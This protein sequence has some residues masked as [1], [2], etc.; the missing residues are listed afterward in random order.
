MAGERTPEGLDS[1]EVGSPHVLAPLPGGAE[2]LFGAFGEA[3]EELYLVGGYVRDLL[4]GRYSEDVDLATSAA[5]QRSLEILE[6]KG[7]KAFPIGMEFGTV[8]AVLEGPKRRVQVEIT[9]YRTKESYRK[10]SRHP[11]VVFGR[12]LRR[13][14]L[15]RDF[16]INAMAMGPGGQLID[17]L[18]GLADL[19]RKLIRTT[20]EAASTFE[21]DPLRMLRAIRFACVLGFELDAGVADA[22]EGMC[23]CIRE[24][25]RER[26]KQELDKIMEVESGERIAEALK[27]MERKGLLTEM[28]PGLEPMVEFGAD[29]HGCYHGKGVWQHTLDVLRRL[30]GSTPCTRWAA[31]FHDCGKP[32]TFS[33]EG[34]DVHFY[35]HEKVSEEIFL[36]AA[37]ELRFSN[38]ERAC[39]AL[40]IRNHMRP[41]QY[42]PQWRDS[43]VNR[44]AR[45]AGDHLGELLEL[46]EADVSSYVEARAAE[47]L[48]SLYS[49][50]ERLNEVSSIVEKKLL[51]SRIGSAIR[52]ALGG[53]EGPRIGRLKS[54]LEDA[55]ADGELPAEADKEI[56]VDYL[57]QRGLLRREDGD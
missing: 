19:R 52:K 29:R 51:P 42:E 16:T 15:R 4:M 45:E 40:L 23:G 30:D 50:R 18:G 32:A 31:L 37:E 57:R 12:S 34:D 55:V 47:G 53:V 1:P 11:D 41:G 28:V 13:D 24:V 9:T 43:A 39:V 22:M 56:Y 3:G 14:L 44:L 21:E 2:R 17:P 27:T 7:F 46:S 36:R 26:W 10:G 33:V 49:L 54:I 6:A 25:S 5:P 35:G 20:R 48:Q 8:A 38:K